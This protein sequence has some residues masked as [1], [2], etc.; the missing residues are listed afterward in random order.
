[1]KRIISEEQRKKISES[2]KGRKWFNDGNKEYFLSLEDGISKEYKVGRINHKI[3]SIKLIHCPC[4][5]YDLEIEDNHNF[6]LSAG[7]FVH[8]SKDSADR[9]CR[10]SI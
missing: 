10:S 8:N 5:V 7:V 4:R 2:S 3:K 9:N 1:M 6:A